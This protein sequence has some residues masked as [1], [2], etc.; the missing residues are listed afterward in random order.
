M[1][2]SPRNGETMQTICQ[3]AS[4]GAKLVSTPTDTTVTHH[5]SW[6]VRKMYLKGVIRASSTLIRKENVMHSATALPNCTTKES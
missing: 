1:K 4:E 3:V 5:S 2:Y 6:P